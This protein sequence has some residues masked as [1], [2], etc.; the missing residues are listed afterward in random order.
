MIRS[1]AVMSGLR[2]DVLALLRPSAG[3]GAMAF[4]RG[5]A[6][7]LATRLAGIVVG[8]FTLTITTRLL[9]A[10]GRGQ[11]AVTMAALA[12]VLQFANAGLHSSATYWLARDPAR[13]HEIAGLLA[14]FSAGPVALLC[15]IAFVAV[16]AFPSIVPEVHLSLLA[17]AL[18]AGPPAMFVLL[19]GNAFLGLGRA[20]AFNVLD[21]S[22][23]VA[24]LC[25]VAALFWWDLRVVFTLYAVFLLAL[26]IGAWVSLAGPSL[27]RPPSRVLLASMFG[28]GSRVFLVSLF[29]FLVLR[30]DLFL[31]NGMS[32]VA[33]AGIYSVAVQVGD[34]LTLTSASVA[35]ILFPHLTAMDAARRWQ[36]TMRVIRLTGLVLAVGALSLAILGPVVFPRWFGKEF[37]GSVVALWWLL[38]GLWCLGVNSLLHQHL[39]AYG[40]PWF[41][42]YSTLAG[43][44]VNVIAN[45]LVIPGYGF[46][47]AAA[48]SSVTY[49]LLLVSTTVY[50]ALPAGRQFKA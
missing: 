4:A 34:V 21:F 42:V 10:E 25:A 11:F 31:L 45:L 30:V 33:E 8:V 18:L 24:G 37:A 23:K 39:A 17:L 9:G 46:V 20:T 47:G 28:F 27:P 43:A 7:T 48:V 5:V 19:A 3:G 15:G 12:L 26:A 13:K 50:L 29:M 40:M 41:L 6:A 22:S 16:W 2:S 14:W 32:G 1:V 38:P 35:A 44:I 36:S 49:T